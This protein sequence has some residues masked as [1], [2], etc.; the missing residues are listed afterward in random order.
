MRPRIL[1]SAYACE[2]DKGSEPEVGWQWAL[3]MARFYDV[4]VLTR[5]NNREAI[6][7]GLAA[8]PEGT[9]V[10]QFVWH[11]ESSFLLGLKRRFRLHRGY[12]TCWQR[13]ARRVIARLHRECPFDLLHHLTFASFRY[14]T[15]IWGHGVPTL[16]GPI[17][18]L[19]S[20]PWRLI[21]TRSATGLVSELARNFS[22][23]AQ[24][25]PSHRIARRAR[26]STKILVS[27]RETQA[28]FA[29]LGKETTLLPTIGIEASHL[30]QEPTPVS[31]DATPG[32]LRLLYVG[33]L[34]PLKGLDLLIAAVELS[35]SNATL[36]LIGGGPQ[37]A[38]LE[39]Q[40]HQAGLRDRVLFLG[41]KSRAEVLAAYRNYH[42][43]VFPSLHDSGG[44]AVIEAMAQGLPVVCLDCGGPAVTVTPEC[45]V[46][47]PLAPG[48][49]SEV[50]ARLAAAIGKYD[51]RRETLIQ[52]GDA[53][54]RRITQHY[55]W[56]RQGE[57]MRKIYGEILGS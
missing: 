45:G 48:G 47:V 31:P 34:I 11:D 33:G 55:E 40:V 25:L 5:A 22:N 37:R 35:S 6:R 23:A 20:V 29:A 28:A 41:Q 57:R 9:P 27:T 52:H 14:P 1:I 4:T 49:R 30:S 13:S 15:A 43:F 51:T 8:L 50:I 24:R 18:G 39:R 17:G 54:R 46:A 16:W 56:T 12:Y 36:T 42:L 53:A 7:R 3:Q 10:P 44:F 38:A 19:E 26:A 2:P 21:P 32:P